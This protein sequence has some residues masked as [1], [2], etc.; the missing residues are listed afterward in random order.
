LRILI[1]GLNYA[2][3]PIGIGPYTSGRI[4]ALMMPILMA[5]LLLNNRATIQPLPA[6]VALTQI[7]ERRMLS[8]GRRPQPPPPA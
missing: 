5:F 7:R 6:S 4:Q 2:P 1:V 8:E 3:E